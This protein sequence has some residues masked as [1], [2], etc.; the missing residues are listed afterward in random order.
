MN[1]TDRCIA[2]LGVLYA[3]VIAMALY[4][5]YATRNPLAGKYSLFAGMCVIGLYHVF[6]FP[7][8]K[9]TSEIKKG[10]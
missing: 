4:T 5:S 8:I 1:A 6:I 10:V 2:I 9:K 7:G 3:I